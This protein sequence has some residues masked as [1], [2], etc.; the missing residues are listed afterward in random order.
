M[1]VEKCCNQKVNNWKCGNENMWWPKMWWLKPMEIENL[2]IKTCG[3]QKPSDKILWWPNSYD[4]WKY[5]KWIPMA[6][7]RHS[8]HH[9]VYND[10]N[11]FSF[12]HL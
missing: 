2:V 3:D 1:V 12:G 6:T 9:M 4:N 5:G 8:S 7:K 11:D 10:W